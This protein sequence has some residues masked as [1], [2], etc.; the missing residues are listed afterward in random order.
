[1]SKKGT[2]GAIRMGLVMGAAASTVL[3]YSAILNLVCLEDEPVMSKEVLTYEHA[4]DAL[5]LMTK[6]VTLTNK[7]LVDLIKDE[8]D[9]EKL[10]RVIA[11]TKQYL[12]KHYN[13][14][15]YYYEKRAA[16]HDEISK[17]S[18]ANGL[19]FAGLTAA[20]G[21]ASGLI[22]EPKEKPEYITPRGL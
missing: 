5:Q 1:M 20:F 17:T 8:N 15:V 9:K 10:S 11:E 22:P 21:I 2:L 13:G 16:N 4:K 7:T 12:K 14:E 18:Y 19:L 6:P 3:T